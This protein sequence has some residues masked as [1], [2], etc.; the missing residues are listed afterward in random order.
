[1]G[2][3]W[4]NDLGV[5]F[6]GRPSPADPSDDRGPGMVAQVVQLA[7]AAGDEA[8]HGYVSDRVPQDPGVDDRGCHAAISTNG[9]EDAQPVVVRYEVAERGKIC[10]K[11]S[12]QFRAKGR[13]RSDLSV[14]ATRAGHDQFQMRTWL[15]TYPVYGPPPRH[16]E[17]DDASRIHDQEEAMA[18]M[19]PHRQVRIGPQ[20]SILAMFAASCR[21]PEACVRLLSRLICDLL[22]SILSAAVF[23]ST[24]ATRRVPGIGAM[25]PP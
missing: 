17:S 12:I 15:V 24:R 22:S 16:G 13:L 10:H 1:M 6:D 8:H 20:R 3:V 2:V 19:V 4:S 18:A 9:T 14:R 25:S 11:D 5:S 21:S 7:K 23:S